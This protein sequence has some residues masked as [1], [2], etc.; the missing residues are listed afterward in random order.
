[1][2]RSRRRCHGVQDGDGV[3]SVDEGLRGI[4]PRC[5]A[6]RCTA[7]ASSKASSA[8]MRAWALA[9]WSAPKLHTYTSSVTAACSGQVCTHK[10]DSASST[11]AVTPPGPFAV[12]GKAW[13]NCPTACRPAALTASRQAWPS[14]VASVSQWGAQRHPWRSAVRCNPCMGMQCSASHGFPIRCGCLM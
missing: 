14:A 12:A 4:S 1:M 11:V 9:L 2:R 7:V 5:S 13:N 6:C 10:W 8:F 3:D